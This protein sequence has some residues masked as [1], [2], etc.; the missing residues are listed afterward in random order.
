MAKLIIGVFKTSQD[1]SIVIDELKKADLGEKEVSVL[2]CK[3][4]HMHKISENT[5]MGEPQAGN[6]GKSVFGM[7]KNVT[8]EIEDEPVELIATGSAARK[9]AGT[10]VGEGTDD[11]IVALMGAGVPRED[12]SQYEEHLIQGHM[13]VMVE[14]KPEQADRVANIFTQHQVVGIE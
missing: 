10:K 8:A 2:S 5:D 9:M 3:I 13:I 11:F 12:A 14:C 6:G 7:L 4:K 1:T